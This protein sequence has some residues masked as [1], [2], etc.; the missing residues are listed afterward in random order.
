MTFNNKMH[1]LI[2]NESL[3]STRYLFYDEYVTSGMTALY[4]ALGNTIDTISSSDLSDEQESSI[5]EIYKNIKV[6][7]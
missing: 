2:D 1:T 6:D 5:R 3:D 7:Y 4:D